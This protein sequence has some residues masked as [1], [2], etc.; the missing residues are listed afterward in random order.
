[1]IFTRT[2]LPAL[3]AAALTF[4]AAAQGD[5]VTLQDGLNGY[6]GT[7]DT[8]LDS[9][10]PDTSLSLSGGIFL[11]GDDVGDDRVRQGLLR[12]DL[13]Q[14]PDGSTINSATLT[15]SRG[16]NGGFSAINIYDLTADF[17]INSA[18]FD[19][20]GDGVQ[21]ATET[22]GA[23]VRT[24]GLGSNGTV[25]ADVTAFVAADAADA[26]ANMGFAL[27]ADPTRSFLEIVSSE[28]GSQALRPALTIDFTPVPEPAS[29]GLLGVAGLGLLRRRR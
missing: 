10:N 2:T 20:T 7:S 16:P 18:T 27:L 11:D 23:V 22:S 6:D 1:M 17:D 28:S 4:A 24:A 26:D 13:S 5:V 19:S 25:T 9:G 21:V 8:T 15:L 12:F 14:I 3:A 29:L